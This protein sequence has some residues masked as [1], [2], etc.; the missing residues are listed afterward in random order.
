RSSGI[1]APPGMHS[2]ACSSAS[3]MSTRTAPF[4]ISS[5]ASAGLMVAIF[6][7]SF[8]AI[9]VVE[10]C[11]QGADALVADPIPERLALAPIGYEAFLPHPGKMLR[12]CRLREID[13]SGEV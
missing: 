6:M 9:E 12:K 8:L 10:N 7:I 5:R 2:R 3:R 11:K 1:L 4:S 13:R